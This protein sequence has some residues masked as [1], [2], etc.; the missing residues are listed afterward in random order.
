MP[1]I[2]YT[3]SKGLVQKS[4]TTDEISLQGQLFSQ[5]DK[6][7]EIATK[8]LAADKLLLTHTLEDSGRQY[9]I[10]AQGGGAKHIL[11]PR[12]VARKTS[13]QITLGGPLTVGKKITIDAFGKPVTFLVV[14]NG[15]AANGA[16]VLADGTAD[17]DGTFIAVRVGGTPDAE[18]GVDNLN[19]AAVD[20]N[21]FGNTVAATQVG[22]DTLRLEAA[23]AGA[24]NNGTITTD[25]ANVTI[26]F[27]PD[28]GGDAVSNTAGFSVKYRLKAQPAQIVQVR[29]GENNIGTTD[30]NVLVKGLMMSAG[31]TGN[32]DNGDDTHLAFAGDANIGD[33][34]E[35]VYDGSG[36]FYVNGLQKVNA[37]VTFA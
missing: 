10:A 29:V 33:F 16:K 11:L 28:D 4:S 3:Q 24:V 27:Q 37:K 20:A 12:T 9:I 7:T 25:D 13:C 6:V 35:F 31:G 21:A 34:A 26:D 23:A 1:S 15:G 19:V 22:T 36:V 30:A 8:A 18:E 17:A 14:A 2:E 5:R 32:A